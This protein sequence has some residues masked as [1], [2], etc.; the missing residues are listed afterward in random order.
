MVSSVRQTK[1]A[2]ASILDV[3]SPAQ[4]PAARCP[5]SSNQTPAMSERQLIWIALAGAVVATGMLVAVAVFILS[6][7]ALSG[8]A[9]ATAVGAA[10]MCVSAWAIHRLP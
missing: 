5:S 7:A 1:S 2:T 6:D 10:S 9:V 3:V 4:L 8:I